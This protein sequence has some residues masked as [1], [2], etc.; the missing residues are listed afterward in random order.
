MRF[1]R[2]EERNKMECGKNLFIRSERYCVAIYL[3][4][5]KED[6]DKEESDSIR[7]QRDLLLRFVQEQKEFEGCRILEFIDRKTLNLIQ[8]GVGKM[9]KKVAI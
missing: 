2:R 9:D 6:G 3:R 8:W 4:L 7:N 5:S 1:I